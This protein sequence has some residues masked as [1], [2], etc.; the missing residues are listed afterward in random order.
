ML[1]PLVPTTSPK[2]N[3]NWCH[4]NNPFFS[5]KLALSKISQRALQFFE[6]FTVTITFTILGDCDEPT[7]LLYYGAEVLMLQ[8]LGTCSYFT[9]GARTGPKPALVVN[10]GRAKNCRVQTLHLI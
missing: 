7:N 2:L 5:S 10:D 4:Y 6:F 1:R 8:A 9:V 3:S